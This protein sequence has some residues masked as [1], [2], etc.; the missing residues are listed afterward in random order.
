[1]RSFRLGRIGIYL[2]AAALLLGVFPTASSTQGATGTFEVYCDSFGLFLANIDGAPAPKEFFLFLYRGFP[3]VGDY[4][5][6]GAWFDVSVYPKGCSAAIKCDSVARGKLLL[7]A[8]HKPDAIRI[9][10]KY[11]ID[12]KGQ[13]L[14]GQFVAK[15]HEYKNPPRICM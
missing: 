12:F 2:S 13:H 5:P 14:T 11:D 1:M 15:R 3:E 4:L 10:G 8:V 6:E 7:D 9:S